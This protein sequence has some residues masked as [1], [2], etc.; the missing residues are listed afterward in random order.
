MKFRQ[1][2]EYNIRNIFL[3]KPYKIQN[4][5][6]NQN[7]KQ[8]QNLAYLWINCLKFYTVCFYGMP[9]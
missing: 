6:Q 2:I 3:E 8:N 7:Q 1:L 4:Q 5:N 9:S